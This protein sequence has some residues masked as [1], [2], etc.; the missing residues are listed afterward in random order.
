MTDAPPR[1][2]V[3]TGCGSLIAEGIARALA[4]NGW[5]LALTDFDLDLARAVADGLPGGS[6]ALVRAMDVTNAPGVQRVIAEVASQ[7]G[8]IDGLVNAAGGGRGLGVPQSDFIGHTSEQRDRI[9]DVNLRGLMTVTH[10]V[11]EH[12]IPAG[13]GAIVSLSAVR[14]LQGGAK[15]AVYSACKA[16]IIVFSQ[17][18]AL[19]VGSHGIRVN[20]VA[21]GDTPARWKTPTAVPGSVLGRG[22]SPEDVGNA[23]EFLLSE[24]ASHITGSCL[25]IS[26]GLALH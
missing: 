22:T 13:R 4:A 19:E 8:R 21:P 26:G 23:V 12:M 18:L 17:S 10:A 3:I 24:R 5:R 1:T 6:V 14:G 16:A 7:C 15:A 9:I 25:D 20:T 2:A 11:L